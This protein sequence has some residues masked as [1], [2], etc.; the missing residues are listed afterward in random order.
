[1]CALV[2]QRRRADH[3]AVIFVTHEI[4]PVLPYADRVLNH[5]SLRHP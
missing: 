3:T 5:T 2:D 4:N 1:M